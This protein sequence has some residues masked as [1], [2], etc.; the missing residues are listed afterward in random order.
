MSKSHN[1]P[2]SFLEGLFIYGLGIPLTFV[3]TLLF[4]P[5]GIFVH[6]FVGSTLWNWFMVPYFDLPILSCYHMYAIILV[7]FSLKPG[8]STAYTETDYNKVFAGLIAPWVIL[9]S[10]Y[11]L[12][13]WLGV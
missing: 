7:A 2:G 6:G 13:Y 11:I 8:V 12:H 3:L 10:G 1:V 4:L 9:F 5:Y